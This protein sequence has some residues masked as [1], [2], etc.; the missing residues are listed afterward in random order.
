MNW[1]LMVWR[2]YAEF[3][4]RSRR[5]E[6][7][8]FVL[9]HVIAILVLSAIGGA[10]IAIFDDRGAFL[11][12][13]VGLY[14]LAGIIPT[15]AVATRRFHDTGKSGWILLLLIILGVIPV[16]GFVAAVIQIVLLCLDGNPGVNQ[17][18]PNPKFPEQAAGIFY[19]SNL[20]TIGIPAQP[21][22]PAVATSDRVCTRC[23]AKLVGESSFCTSCGAQLSTN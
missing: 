11:F 6:Y 20:A 8:M 19:A 9:F 10:G 4:G 12:I 18:G 21:Q 5:K 2:R 16:V 15:L 1:Y 17:Y 13:P 23:G 22:P 14:S 3:D 7:W